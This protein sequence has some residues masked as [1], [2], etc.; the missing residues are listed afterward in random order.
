MSLIVSF[1][2]KIGDTLLQ[3]PVA[4]QLAQQRG[5]K[6]TL[7]LDA[8]TLKPLDR[9][10]ASQ[11]CV[12]CVEFKP[13]I[14]N[15]S[16]GGQPW[17][18]GLK[19]E[20][21]VGH[22]VY[23]LGFRGFPQR[24]ITLQTAL[25]SGLQLDTDRLASEPSLTVPPL[26]NQPGRYV[27][28]HGTYQSHMTG[29]PRFW[30]ALRNMRKD[31]EANF[32][33]I[34]WTGTADERARSLEL[35]PDWD[36]FDDGGDFHE[37]ARLMAG[38]SLVVGAGSSGVALAGALKVPCVRVHDPIGDAARVI[39]SNLGDNQWNET[40]ADLRVRWPDIIQSLVGQTVA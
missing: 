28:L 13:G 9:L 1:P 3:W 21:V 2:G 12:E 30:Y 29:C 37:L 10:L 38:A 19:T 6:L 18:F 4:Y 27:V 24:Q 33:R 23:H 22:E 31:L 8:G 20:D 14:Q 35:Y 11:A 26:E 39:W 34:I 16:C 7:W 32:D 17:D 25:D 36:E 5:A 40:E 15:Y